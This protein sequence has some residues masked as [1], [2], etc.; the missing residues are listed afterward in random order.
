MRRAFGRHIRNFVPG[1]SDVAWCPVDAQEEIGVSPLCARQSS[2]ED[3]PNVVSDSWFYAPR[4]FDSGPP[5]FRR[6]TP[7]LVAAPN[8][9]PFTRF[10]T[11]STH[12][13]PDAPTFP[14]MSEPSENSVT[15]AD[16]PSAFSLASSLEKVTRTS[17]G[18]THSASLLAEPTILDAGCGSAD[19]FVSFRI[20]SPTEGAIEMAVIHAEAHVV[21]VDLSHS[22]YERAPANFQFV[23]MDVT[24]GLPPC[25]DAGGYDVIHAR[26]LTRH[27]KN[28]A[29]FLQ[30]AY[31]ALKP[32][33][34]DFPLTFILIISRT[35]ATR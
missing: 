16:S 19:W 32:A 15:L 5:T 25:R 24:E 1:D 26:S 31:S 2:M 23:Q 34:L 17:T 33:T 7:N 3:I 22:F 13:T 27:L 9:T 28:P 6:P 21:G 29:D 14:S 10:T 4:R 20:P 11:P 12:N 30:M 35:Q 8:R 18:P